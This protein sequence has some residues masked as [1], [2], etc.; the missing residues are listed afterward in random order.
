VTGRANRGMRY[1]RSAFDEV[2]ES[3]RNALLTPGFTSAAEARSAVC[4][5]GEA[6]T[7]THSRP[8]GGGFKD[9]MSCGVCGN[10]AFVRR[11]AASS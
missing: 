10:T 11:E 8:T 7:H 9:Y 1:G 2:S 3:R 4:T 6:M 5:C